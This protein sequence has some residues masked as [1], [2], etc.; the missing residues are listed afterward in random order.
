MPATA[1][2]AIE[3]RPCQ[4]RDYADDETG[5]SL[6]CDGVTYRKFAPGHDARLKGFLIKS[7]RDGHKIRHRP[8]GDVMSPHAAAKNYGFADLVRTG[9]DRPEPPQAEP[10]PP[11]KPGM[12]VARVGRWSYPGRVRKLDGKRVFV[13]RDRQGNERRAT[14]FEITETASV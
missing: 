8:T 7:G 9:I 5:V 3:L 10:Q 13:Y 14:D 1:E 4:C 2:P 6:S 11:T 12:A